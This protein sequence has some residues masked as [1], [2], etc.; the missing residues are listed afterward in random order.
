MFGDQTSPGRF[1]MFRI[2][3]A[4]LPR[5]V[6]QLMAVLL[7]ES[8]A[9]VSVTTQTS[10]NLHQMDLNLTPLCQIVFTAGTLS[11]FLH[12]KCSHV[13]EFK[14]GCTL[15]AVKH[16]VDSLTRHK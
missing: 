10:F 5:E 15:R 8:Q 4:I 2:K 13:S 6:F 14:H 11:K 7:G 9:K 16:S 1:G 12:F 3:T